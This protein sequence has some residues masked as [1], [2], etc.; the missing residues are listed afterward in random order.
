MTTLEL[1]YDL[2]DTHSRQLKASIEF[3]S[4][5]NPSRSSH[6][7]LTGINDH[8][9]SILTHLRLLDIQVLPISTT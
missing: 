4:L 2:H 7:A 3:L 5:Q 9:V 1:S 6:R 8:M